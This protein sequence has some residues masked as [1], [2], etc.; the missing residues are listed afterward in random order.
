[1]NIFGR[2]QQGDEVGRVWTWCCGGGG[3]REEGEVN[4]DARQDLLRDGL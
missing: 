2:L 4:A 1:M 3:R